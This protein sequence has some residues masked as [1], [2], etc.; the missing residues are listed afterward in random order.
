LSLDR[1]ATSDRERNSAAPPPSPPPLSRPSYAPL[2]PP[3]PAASLPS[4]GAGAGE[5]GGERSTGVAGR[6]SSDGRL[7]VPSA[8]AVAPV[9][10]PAPPSPSTPLALRPL[11]EKR[12]EKR[13]DKEK[14]REGKNCA[15]NMWVPRNFF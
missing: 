8:A 13:E 4:V 7:V 6:R 1:S 3:R 11:P 10:H 5:R 12:G 2:T 14:K 9:A 15:A